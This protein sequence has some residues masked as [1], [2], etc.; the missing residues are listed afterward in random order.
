MPGVERAAEDVLREGIEVG[1][2]PAGAA[3]HALEGVGGVGGV[4]QGVLGL[5][6][7]D[8][9]LRQVDALEVGRLR[10]DESAAG[11]RDGTGDG[12]RDESHRARVDLV[13][14]VGRGEGDGEPLLEQLV[15]DR[16]LAIRAPQQVLDAERVPLEP[17]ALEGFAVE[18]DL[19]DV[20]EVVARGLDHHVEEVPGVVAH[21]HDEHHDHAHQERRLRQVLDAAI[22][23]GEYGQ[24][25]EEGDARD[26]RVLGVEGGV[27]RLEPR[28]HAHVVAHRDSAIAARVA[29]VRAVRV[30][31][32]DAARILALVLHLAADAH[33]ELETGRE[34]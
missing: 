14:A 29:H 19:H 31:A 2:V 22:D 33:H 4:H 13:A 5:Q 23:A 25:R 30:Q 20:G 6:G 9:L 7:V 11:R 28:A 24:R 17:K 16:V 1:G 26:D 21:E 32:P 15:L 12:G 18:A 8:R 3:R 34:L 27:L 10:R